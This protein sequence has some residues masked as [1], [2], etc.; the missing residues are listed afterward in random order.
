MA[1]PL[2]QTLAGAQTVS[3]TI[4]P[5]STIQR[6]LHGP[7]VRMTRTNREEYKS[8]EEKEKRREKRK[9]K[10]E[11]EKKKICFKKRDEIP[12]KK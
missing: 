3:K 1:Q 9:E 11:E 4:V 10:R 8:E 5:A 12:F 6:R 2:L 7:F